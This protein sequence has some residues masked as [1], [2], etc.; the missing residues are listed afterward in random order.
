MTDF[1]H[2]QIDWQEVGVDVKDISCC[3]LQRSIDRKR[4]YPLYLLH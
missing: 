3:G 2:E 4:C 1:V